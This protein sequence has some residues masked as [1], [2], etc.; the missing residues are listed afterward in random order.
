MTNFQ[1]PGHGLAVFCGINTLKLL[2]VEIQGLRVSKGKTTSV[3]DCVLVYL[4]PRYNKQEKI[5]CEVYCWHP[6]ERQLRVWRIK[7]A[8]EEPL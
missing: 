1:D 2:T 7:C 4:I 8:N 5:D 6:S 3:G